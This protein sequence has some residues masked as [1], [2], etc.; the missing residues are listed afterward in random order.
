[1]TN[2][3]NMFLV[4]AG[5]WQPFHRGHEWVVKRMLESND[6]ALL[7]IVN[8]DPNK[9]PDLNFDRFKRSANP[10]T[11]WVRYWMLSRVALHLGAEQ[12]IS[13]LPS[14]HPRKSIEPEKYF[15]PHLRYLRWCVPLASDEE[16]QKAEDFQALGLH[17]ATIP[18]IPS[19][20]IAY[21]AVK[22]RQRI[23]SGESNWKT[24]L[25]ESIIDASQKAK[26]DIGEVI[27]RVYQN[28]IVSNEDMLIEAAIIPGWFSP[29]D[30][31]HETLIKDAIQKFDVVHIALLVEISGW[32][33]GPV[34][35]HIDNTC[36]MSYWERYHA[37]HKLINNKKW[38]S[39]ITIGPLFIDGKGELQDYETY[40]PKSRTWIIDRSENKSDFL[41]TKLTSIGESVRMVSSL[42]D[43]RRELSQCYIT[44]RVPPAHLLA[45]GTTEYIYSLYL[46][47]R[48]SRPE[49]VS[50]QTGGN[51]GK[52]V[53]NGPVTIQ[54]SIVSIDGNQYNISSLTADDFRGVLYQLITSTASQEDFERTINTIELDSNSLSKDQIRNSAKDVAL[55]IL[56]KNDA[57]LTERLK[58]IAN[59]LAMG[60]SGS[61]IATA[62]VEGFKLII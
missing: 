41:V 34:G 38:Y 14:W 33:I 61:L 49:I 8:P 10:F 27:K 22:I 44:D 25:P 12:R 15:F 16:E 29:P 19:N 11:Y 40:V 56:G 20:I 9:P 48:H 1:M 6:S 42:G 17:V 37:L 23:L 55:T 46:Q 51:M 5:R 2:H 31:L 45:T 39:S 50:T 24:Y 52:F 54:G 3:N 28:N 62:I 18:D 13:I 53:F 30:C 60:A 21:S 59:Q 36:I 47:T 7:A 4:L 43:E 32:E 57:Q 26:L 58:N 35:L